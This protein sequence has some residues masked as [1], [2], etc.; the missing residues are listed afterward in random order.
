VGLLSNTV[1]LNN[2]I[3]DVAGG[4]STYF[5]TSWQNNI[6]SGNQLRTA[7]EFL[8]VSFESLTLLYGAAAPPLPSVIIFQNN[9]ITNNSFSSPRYINGTMQYSPSITIDLQDEALVS[10]QDPIPCPSTQDTCIPVAATGN[11]IKNNIFPTTVSGPV[12]WPPSIISDG[13]GNVCGPLPSGSPITC[14]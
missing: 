9:Y 12:I 3:E 1:I 14:N 13:G 10:G 11:V 8:S 7:I 2:N 4:I 5:N 6:V